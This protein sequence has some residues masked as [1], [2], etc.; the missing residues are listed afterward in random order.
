MMLLLALALSPAETWQDAFRA[1]LADPTNATQ[2]PV[3]QD[4]LGWF[5]RSNQSRRFDVA[6]TDALRNAERT[7]V[8]IACS[9]PNAARDLRFRQASLRVE[10]LLACQDRSEC[11][12]LARAVHEMRGACLDLAVWQAESTLLASTSEGAVAAR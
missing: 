4:D 12:E 8:L 1:E 9:V 3:D 10:G 7:D 11:G 2:L 5:A 6:L